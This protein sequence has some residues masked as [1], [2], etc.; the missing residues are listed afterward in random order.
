MELFWQDTDW[1]AIGKSPLVLIALA[2]TLLISG[3]NCWKYWNDPTKKANPVTWGILAVL[4]F[5]VS[6]MQVVAGAGLATI[7]LVT[8]GCLNA[9]NMIAGIKKGSTSSFTLESKVCVALSALG[10]LLWATVS[11]TAIASICLTVASLVAF[12]PTIRS[13]QDDHNS[14]VTGTFLANGFRYGLTALAVAHWSFNSQLYVVTWTIANFAIYG[15]IHYRRIT[16]VERLALQ[17]L[18]RRIELI[19]SHENDYT[20]VNG[21]CR[22]SEPF[23]DSEHAAFAR[24]RAQIEKMVSDHGYGN[25]R[26]DAS[27]FDDR[28]KRL[29]IVERGISPY[30][31]FA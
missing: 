20:S 10:T 1:V 31:A 8:T 2:M 5:V 7:V 14:Q 12:W 28:D 16:A 15:Y 22:S 24:N 13:I 25:W 27:Q 4:A 18:S 26:V 17:S 11:V 3:V 6:G 29:L 21:W 30:P 19:L 23:N 9:T